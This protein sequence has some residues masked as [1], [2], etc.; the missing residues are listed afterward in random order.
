MS[1]ALQ[2]PMEIKVNFSVNVGGGG[3]GRV[4]ADDRRTSTRT[5][6]VS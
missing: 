3:G 4:A 6:V 5:K 2:N 1:F